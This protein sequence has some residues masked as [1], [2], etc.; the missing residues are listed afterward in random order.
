ME[1]STDAEPLWN[2]SVELADAGLRSVRGGVY[3]VSGYLVGS[4][5]SAVAAI[6]LLRYLGVANFG[7]YATVIDR[8]VVLGLSDLGL[9]L[10]GQRDY[11]FQQTEE[12]RS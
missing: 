3:R 11:M 5:F 4:A 10:V 9:T 8:C 6:L 2:D 1:R 12:R 7:R